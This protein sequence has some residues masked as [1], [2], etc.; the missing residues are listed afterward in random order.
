M[1]R[2]L[3]ISFLGRVKKKRKE[4]ETKFKLLVAAKGFD[5][6]IMYFDEII[7]D[8]IKTDKYQGKIQ[9]LSLCRQFD[10]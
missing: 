7:P 8:L 10:L 2:L 4:I 5:C 6:E 9:L 3:H 1:F